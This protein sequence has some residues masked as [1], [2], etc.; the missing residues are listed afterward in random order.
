MKGNYFFSLSFI[1]LFSRAA[2][3]WSESFPFTKWLFFIFLLLNFSVGLNLNLINKKN[4]IK[5]CFY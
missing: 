3:T 2:E 1:Y 4:R 5:N